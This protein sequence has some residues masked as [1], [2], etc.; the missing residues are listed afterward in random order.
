MQTMSPS[1]RCALMN[2]PPSQVSNK[3]AGADLEMTN[4]DLSGSGQ[5]IVATAGSTLMLSMDYTLHETRC[6]AN[7]IDQIE[8]GW[9]QGSNGPRSGC[10]FDA[11]V[12]KANGVMG[13]VQG[14]SITAPMTSGNYDL[15]TNIGQ[16]T[17]CGSGSWFAGEVPDPSTTIARLCVR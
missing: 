13:Q 3:P 14:F 1:A 16:N 7:C 11:A 2:S 12:S 10:V 6:E 9:M 8:V 5:M 17:S 15:R 4:I